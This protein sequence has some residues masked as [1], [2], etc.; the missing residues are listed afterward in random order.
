VGDVPRNAYFTSKTIDSA[1]ERMIGELEALGLRRPNA[2]IDRSR[3]ALLLLD[4]QRYFADPSSH[5]FVPSLPTIVPRV[6]RTAMAFL[7]HSR[8]VFLTR[9]IDDPSSPMRAWWR[10]AIEEKDERSQLIADLQ[11]LDA[12]VLVKSAYDAFLGTSLAE[13][14]S[15]AQ[16]GQVIVGGA[17]THLCCETTA[18][19]AFMKG[20]QVFFLADGTATYNEEFH[21]ATLTNLAHGFA[22]PVLCTDVRSALGD[23]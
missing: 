22:V 11:T 18:R 14:L 9:H 20:Y 12:P 21:R 19:A 3:A 10:G 4:C 7:R 5:A 6:L 23:A 2:A 15:A 8:P 1:A 17:L 13:Q 16:V